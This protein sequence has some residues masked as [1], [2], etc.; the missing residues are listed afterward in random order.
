SPDYNCFFSS[1]RNQGCVIEESPLIYNNGTYSIDFDDFERRC[2][3]PKTRVFLLCNPHNPA[4]RVWSREELIRMGEICLRHGVFVLAD[5]IHC[6]LTMPG[7]EY[8]PFASISREF[9]DNCA[10]CIAPT[11]A[12]NIAGLQIANIVVPN[13][14]H[15]ERVDRA[16]NIHENCDV[17]PFG[18][19][20]LQTAYNECEDWLD[21]LR[22]YLWDNYQF[23]C[24]YF[25]DNMPGLQV[26]R[27]EGT[28]LVWVNIS[29]TRKTALELCQ[30]LRKTQHLWLNEGEMYGETAGRNFVRINIACPRKQ[31]EEALRR[32]NNGLNTII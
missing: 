18:V 19:L 6:E 30:H 13:A 22:Q 28:Y 5:E 27:L 31:L 7:Y 9:A 2:V 16:I 26:T 21:E 29:A 23:L 24:K 4:G 15:F 11:K 1:I 12:F 32:L 8:T 17:N 25:A 14:K 10:V 20:A 3:D